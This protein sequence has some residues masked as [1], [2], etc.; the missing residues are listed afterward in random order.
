M[1]DERF[2]Q[3]TV[4]LD[5]IQALDKWYLVEV[6]ANT[7]VWRRTPSIEPPGPG[8]FGRSRKWARLSP[9]AP[10]STQIQQLAD[11]LTWTRCVIHE[12]SKGPLVAEFA[13]ARVTNA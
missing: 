3:N 9:T 4:F 11:N 12:G 6:P 8:P 2:G 7:P 10:T 1:G 13:F 5:G